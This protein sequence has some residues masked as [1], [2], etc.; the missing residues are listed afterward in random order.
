[1]QT[2]LYAICPLQEQTF[3][4]CLIKELMLLLLRICSDL[5]QVDYIAQHSNVQKKLFFN[6]LRFL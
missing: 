5:F 4:I 6:P 3:I 1:M 2:S